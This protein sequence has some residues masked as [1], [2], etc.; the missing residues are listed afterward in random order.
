MAGMILEVQEAVQITDVRGSVTELWLLR[1][2]G[3][4]VVPPLF[5]AAIL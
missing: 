4:F 2:L 1:G 3:W 5:I